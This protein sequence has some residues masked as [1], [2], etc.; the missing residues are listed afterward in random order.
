MPL[1]LALLACDDDAEVVATP[2]DA[3]PAPTFVIH[4]VD[5]A[6]EPRTAERAWAEDAGGNVYEARCYDAA[7]T[8]WGGI[9]TEGAVTLFAAAGGVESTG[10]PDVIRRSE[11]GCAV[12]PA[13]ATV[14]IEG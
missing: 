3:Y 11:D 9:A 2:C 7:C 10:V 14:A 8:E 1:L 12:D 13:E 4:V 5:G 6:G